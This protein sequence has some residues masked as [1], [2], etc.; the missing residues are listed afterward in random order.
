MSKTYFS[1]FSEYWAI[2]KKLSE[3]QRAM[4]LGSLPE[5]QVKLIKKCYK[6]E[7]W[8]DLFI[9][10][11]IDAIINEFK[12]KYNIDIYEIRRS[13]LKGGGEYSIDKKVWLQIVEAFANFSGK[14]KYFILG[15]IKETKRNENR[16]FLAST[17]K[18]NG[19]K[20]AE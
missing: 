18:K 15:G 12:D 11:Q 14:H 8:E 7:G 3:G 4:I 13:I 19:K 10:N 17:N 20:K 9:R 1:N 5:D 16:V 6:D 2:A